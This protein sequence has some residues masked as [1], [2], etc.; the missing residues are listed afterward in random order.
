MLPYLE[1]LLLL[2]LLLLADSSCFLEVEV[3]VVGCQVVKRSEQ[4]S[5]RKCT[6][7]F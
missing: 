4:G 1:L 3:L 5:C 2:L 6:L 7:S